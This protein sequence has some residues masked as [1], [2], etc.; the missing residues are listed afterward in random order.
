MPNVCGNSNCLNCG[1]RNEQST[2]VTTITVT[3]K[4]LEQML[5]EEITRQSLQSK[6][7]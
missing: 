3:L 6:T 7:N 2:A 5:I 1:S 4:D